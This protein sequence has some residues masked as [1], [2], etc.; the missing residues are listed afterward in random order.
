MCV[1]TSVVERQC[2]GL[3]G[4]TIFGSFNVGCPGSCGVQCT[5]AGNRSSAALSS[6]MRL[7]RPPLP[8]GDTPWRH[9]MDILGADQP[10][11]ILPLWHSPQ[12]GMRPGSLE[13]PNLDKS[14]ASSPLF[15]S[16]RLILPHIA[17]SPKITIL[18]GVPPRHS[19]SIPLPVELSFYTLCAPTSAAFGLHYVDTSFVVPNSSP[20]FPSAPRQLRSASANSGCCTGSSPPPFQAHLAGRWRSPR[21]HS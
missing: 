20:P 12:R 3:Y 4:V 13:Y 14:R 21:S 6:A 7:P 19:A 9:A 15:C 11:Q 8:A 18:T 2:R 5:V 17:A 10:V 1:A 16:C